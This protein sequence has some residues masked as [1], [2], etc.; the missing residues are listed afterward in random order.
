MAAYRDEAA[1]LEERHR[2]LRRALEET[3]A[4]SSALS[5]EEAQLHQEL[6]K[7]HRELEARAR[8]PRRSLPMVSMLI[9]SPCDVPWEKMVGDERVRHCGQCDKNVHNLSAMTT[10]EAHAFLESVTRASSETGAPLPCLNLWQRQD[11]T[12]ITADCPVGVRRRR[13]RSLLAASLGVGALAVIAATALAVMG[14]SPASPRSFTVTTSPSIQ[15]I[16]PTAYV[17]TSGYIAVEGAPGIRIYDDHGFVGVTPLTYVAKEGA[18]SI[19]A[20]DPKDGRTQL[21]TTYV[22][23]QSVAHVRVDMQ[24][25]PPIRM[26]GAPPPSLRVGGGKR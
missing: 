13:M 15:P 19:R 2:Q 4:R 12:V 14:A 6:A 20:E 17:D 3:R 5:R 11:G 23:A 26:A 21:L 1:S 18:H 8:A 10:D 22:Q 24:P 25:A 7:I 9:A 16:A